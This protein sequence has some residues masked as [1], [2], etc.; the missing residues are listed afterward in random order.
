MIKVVVIDDESP[1]RMRV[2][3]MIANH[4]E[5]LQLLGEADC[6]KAGIALVEE[7]RPE[8]LFLDIQMPDMSG[9]ELLAALSYQPM[10]V[11]TTAYAAYAVKAFEQFSVDYLVKPLR[12]ER[13]RMAVEKLEK[14]SGAGR[15]V[16]Y[17]KLE[18]IFEGMRPKARPLSLPIKKRDRIILVE[19]EDIAFLKAEDKYV[20]VAMKDGTSHLLSKAI[21]QLENEL[22]EIFIR[23][24]RSYIVNSTYIFEIQK[25]FKGK[26]ILKL[27]DRPQ[28]SITTGESYSAKIKEILGL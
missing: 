18:S 11:F 21:G 20:K 3:A 1:A 17:A 16:D 28:T 6:G 19:F 27:K 2:K 13:F 23:A 9:F 4:P 8:A 12:A 24:H 14:F 15:G 5:Q 26:L 25:Y 10:I 7:L 22:P